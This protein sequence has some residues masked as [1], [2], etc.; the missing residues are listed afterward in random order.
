MI[1]VFILTSSISVEESLYFTIIK[2]LIQNKHP[3]A[4]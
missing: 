4:A 1:L 3:H 2:Q